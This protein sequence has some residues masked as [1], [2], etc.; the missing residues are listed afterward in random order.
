M[1]K[2]YISLKIL[3]LFIENE[4]NRTINN[5]FVRPSPLS[6]NQNQ[7]INLTNENQNGDIINHVQ[8]DE[9]NFTNLTNNQITS[10]I[11]KT[12]IIG[13]TMKNNYLKSNKL[14][15]SE[16]LNNNTNNKISEHMEESRKY[17]SIRSKVP[18]LNINSRSIS[19]NK[20]SLNN[21]PVNKE[22]NA[23]IRN[24]I[25]NP[26]EKKILPNNNKIYKKINNFEKKK[27]NLKKD[28]TT[29]TNFKRYESNN[30]KIFFNENVTN[31]QENMQSNKYSNNLNNTMKSTKSIKRVCSQAN[32]KEKDK[33]KKECNFGDFILNNIEPL[34][35]NDLN[36]NSKNNLEIEK[37]E[38]SLINECMSFMNIIYKI[39]CFFFDCR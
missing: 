20:T 26:V 24:T 21:T 13:M 23:N 35:I 4:G 2:K 17:E 19:K 22:I 6:T 11:N 5:N 10:N 27:S 28:K 16:N 18:L 36:R 39:K 31:S 34:K 9:K 8:S 37:I 33:C 1:K 15:T 7:I 38:K 12:E 29:K 3:K 14:K 30:I 32:S 25:T